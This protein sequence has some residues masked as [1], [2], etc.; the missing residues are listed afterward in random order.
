[1]KEV[2]C[3]VIDRMELLRTEAIK[4]RKPERPE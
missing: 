3:L 2:A 4:F 1:M